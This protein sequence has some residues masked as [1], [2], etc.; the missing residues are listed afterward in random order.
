MNSAHC[1]SRI[2]HKLDE[3]L[4][5]PHTLSSSG[6]S[7][8]IFISPSSSSSDKPHAF[9]YRASIK[10]PV[11][12]MYYQKGQSQPSTTKLLPMEDLASSEKN[13]WLSLSN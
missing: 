7:G 9:G 8:D 2:Y 3:D 10:P 13:L 12:S 5:S 1:A 11:P 4:K 6:K